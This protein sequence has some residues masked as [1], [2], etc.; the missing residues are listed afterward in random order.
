MQVGAVVMIKSTI[1]M[2]K[3]LCLAVVFLFSMYWVSNYIFYVPA[4]NSGL[5]Q[6]TFYQIANVGQTNEGLR[7]LRINV[8][9][10]MGANATTKYGNETLLEI[11][12][13]FDDEYTIERLIE[14][15]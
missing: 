11:A 13:R 7:R 14:S 5:P 1:L 8:A 4:F 12:R 3:A 9:I 6:A 2:T 15:A 10:K